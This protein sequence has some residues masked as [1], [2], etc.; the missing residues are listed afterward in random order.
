V[1]P[2][3][4]YASVFFSYKGLSLSSF[5]FSSPSAGCS[6]GEW[7]SNTLHVTSGS[8]NPLPGESFPFPP[9]LLDPYVAD[10]A[11]NRP[12]FMRS[13]GGSDAGSSSRFFPRQ[14]I[15]PLLFSSPGIPQRQGGRLMEMVGFFFFFLPLSDR[16]VFSS[17]FFPSLIPRNTL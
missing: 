5:P 6:A 16:Q 12:L 10:A 13:H 2:P 4:A 7:A 9:S 15:P 1:R 17:S 14:T 11:R 3:R 8:V